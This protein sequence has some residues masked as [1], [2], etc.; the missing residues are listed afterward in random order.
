MVKAFARIVPHIK[1]LSM[2]LLLSH[3]KTI[4]RIAKP[5]PPLNF[6]K[7]HAF[8]SEFYLTMPDPFHD[9]DD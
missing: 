1:K 8:L 9:Y 4:L 2:R 7:T 6:R 5:V 3:T